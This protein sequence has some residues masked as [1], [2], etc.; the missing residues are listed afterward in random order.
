M[1]GMTFP[2][3]ERSREAAPG[4]EIVRIRK[5]HERPKFEGRQ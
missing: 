1:G 2:L 4:I 3:M 5:P